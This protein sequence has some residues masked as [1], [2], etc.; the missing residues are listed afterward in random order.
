MI[1]AQ[2]MSILHYGQGKKQLYGV[3]DH[4]LNVIFAVGLTGSSRI[5]GIVRGFGGVEL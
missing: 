4:L 1:I 3:S 5:F 2:G